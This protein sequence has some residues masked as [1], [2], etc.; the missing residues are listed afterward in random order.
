MLERHRHWSVSGV[1]GA[2]AREEAPRYHSTGMQV[3]EGDDEQDN[4]EDATN[5]RP[6]IQARL[7]RAA[8]VIV[9]D[10]WANR[11][12]RNRAPTDIY[13]AGT[14]TWVKKPGRGR[15]DDRVDGVTIDVLLSPSSTDEMYLTLLETALF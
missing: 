7:R 8:E 10:T 15:G 13:Q 2:G 14:K 11:P 9:A 6:D 5:S 3:Q 1:P 12:Q 4:D